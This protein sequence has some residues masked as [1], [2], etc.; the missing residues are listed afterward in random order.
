MP[1]SLC[2]AWCS[3]EKTDLSDAK[4]AAEYEEHKMAPFEMAR[5]LKTNL[6]KGLSESDAAERLETNGPN[7]LTP[8]KKTPEWVKFLEEMT[9][10]FSLLLWAGSALCFIGYSLKQEA[11]NLYLG[12]VLALVT[13]V[14]GCFSY[15]QNAKSENLMKS[16]AGM[17]PPKVKVVRTNASGEVVMKE[18]NALDLVVGDLVKVIGGDLI[19]ADIRLTQCSDNMCVDNASLTGESEPQK[20]SPD[21]TDD[22]VLETA[23]LA[24][25]GTQVPEGEATGVVISTGDDT[26]MGRIAKL[27][28]STTAEQTPIN[29]EIENFVHVISGIAFALGVSFFLVGLSMG[30]DHITNLVFMIG[31]IVANVPE[32]LLATVT[33]CLTLTANRMA[34]KMVLV[35]QLEGVETLGSTSCICSDKT[36]TLTQNIMT[37]V[38][39]VYAGSGSAEIRECGT[40]YTNNRYDC[41]EDNPAFQKLLRCGVLCNV[42]FFDEG[43]KFEEIEDPVTKKKTSGEKIPFRSK[44]VQGDGSVIETINWEPR[45]N[46]S[47]AAMIKF[48]QPIRDVEEWRSKN[49]G[50]FKIPF[51]SANKYQVHIHQQ[52]EHAKGAE[53][54]GPRVVL[55]KGAPERVLK[56]CTKIQVGNKIIDMTDEERENINRLQD[57]LSSNGL[58]VLGFAEATLPAGEYPATFDDS[59]ND[60]KAAKST[61][62]FP[63]G[64]EAFVEERTAKMAKWKADLAAA[65]GDKE[66]HD[67][68]A[69]HEPPTVSAK[70]KPG[71]VFLGLMAL[72]DPPR[73][74]VPG[75]VAKC[76]TAGIKV[77]MVTGDHP[78][79]AEAISYKVGILWSIT[80]GGCQ[81]HNKAKGFVPGD[82][83]WKDPDDAEAIVMPGWDVPDPDA[84]EYTKEDGT[85]APVAEFWDF[86][87]EHPQIVFARTSPQQKLQIVENCQRLGHVVAVTGDGVNDSPALKQAH[88]GVA[89][90]I[91]GSEVSKNA[92]DMILMDDNFASIVAGVEEGRLIFDN[93]KKSI[94]YTLTSNIPEISPFLCFITLQTPLPLSVILILGIDLGTDMVPAISMAYEE[95]EA[96]IMR[97]PPRNSAVD[98]LV[99][100]KLIFFAY[101]QIGVMQAMAGFYT[102]LVVLNDYGYPPSILRGLGM[103]DYWQK[104]PLHC[105]FHGG[106]YVSED[107]LIDHTR[108]P[109]T[110]APASDYPFWDSGDGGYIVDCEFPLKNFQGKSGTPGGFKKEDSSTY[111]KKTEDTAHIT[112]ESIEALLADNFYEYLPWK[113]RMSPYWSSKWLS[114]YTGKSEAPGGALGEAKAVTY[115]NYQ[116]LGLW[117]VCLANPS[118]TPLQKSQTGTTARATEKAA[119][120]SKEFALG[121]STACA[122]V[123]MQMSD[124]AY[125]EAVFCSGDSATDPAACS[126]LQGHPSQVHY[127]KKA[128]HCSAGCDAPADGEDKVQ[129]ANIASRMMQKEALHH[130]QSAYFVT[131]VVVQW[132]D[133]LI[134]KTRWLSITTQGLRNSTLNF[135]LFFETLLAAWLCYCPAINMGL[136]TR[137]MR[138]VHWLPGLPWS[139][140]IF[141][142][143]E[144]RKAL[145]RATS[146]ESVDAGTGQVY[147]KAGWLERNT[148]Y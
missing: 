105:K 86:V 4:A 45:G 137:N 27:T 148:Y 43:T 84:T 5:K 31:I 96:D 94:C 61:P 63:L 112:V 140:L 1:G 32:G 125:D 59:Y 114:W 117:S 69:R 106:M 29:K 98:R 22:A 97:R 144:A 129:C 142:Y 74:A 6:E 115:F 120:A 66:A 91:M 111:D 19:P 28:M 101:L 95:A 67:E 146:P 104:Q 20:R 25:F 75:A 141:V 107:G 51:N 79:T 46:A 16:F 82:A 9:G 42:C 116:P 78:M 77:I 33:V 60:G 147:R 121:T 88:I 18:I 44:K 50:V 68:V 35:K 14:T 102:W 41:E 136:G 81:R 11:D 73:P 10:F 145:M 85:V 54:K 15:Y 8:P 3:T 109:S 138:L 17:M 139:C 24:F 128:D 55:M 89:M 143:D 56:R 30:T 131:I 93:L 26:V 113:G 80:R 110:T 99:T 83:G 52:E 7:R 103:G 126:V 127:C 71:L 119:K 108:D 37:V 118:T 38:E 21:C 70:S 100:K 39:I 76:K 13:F 135:G 49:T 72:I 65:A 90:G 53:N 124:K 64:E 134:C 92:A 133:L 122:G 36:G 62:N 34:T 123:D 23:N 57:K 40:P 132:A 2:P 130:A 58:R 47:E 48:A 87:L 12:I